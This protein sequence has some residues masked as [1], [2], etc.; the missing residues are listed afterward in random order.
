[1]K[2]EESEEKEE[3]TEEQ[4]QMIDIIMFSGDEE[5]VNDNLA[6]WEI[7]TMNQNLIEIDMKFQDPLN[8]S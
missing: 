3:A 2:G 8:V 7:V 6:D 5:V 1:M 4:T